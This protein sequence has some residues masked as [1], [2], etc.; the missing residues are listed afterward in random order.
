MY[1]SQPIQCEEQEEEREATNAKAAVIIVNET[2]SFNE[3][4]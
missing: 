2:P 3:K 4:L 1:E